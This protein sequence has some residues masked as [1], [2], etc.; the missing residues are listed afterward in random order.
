[1]ERKARALLF[2]ALSLTYVGSLMLFLHTADVIPHSLE[3]GGR[4]IEEE[5][6]SE[7]GLWEGEVTDS[8]VTSV[9]IKSLHNTPRRTYTFK[10]TDNDFEP[11]SFQV[12]ERGGNRK[13]GK[14]SE[15]R[16]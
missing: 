11:K 6:V 15:R 8:G 1:M 5:R 14:E 9:V 7:R 2:A 12:G 13:R 4:E 3:R 16:E 10:Q